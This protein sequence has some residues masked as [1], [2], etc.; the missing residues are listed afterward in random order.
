MRGRWLFSCATAF[1]LACAD[2]PEPFESAAS[3][4]DLGCPS[5][6]LEDRGR[7]RCDCALDEQ[8]TS[9]GCAPCPLADDGRVVLPFES[10]RFS[11]EVIFDGV[12]PGPGYSSG[13][14]LVI[15]QLGPGAS[16]IV[17]STE[18][19]QPGLSMGWDLRVPPG[20]YQVD[21]FNLSREPSPV[22]DE[23]RVTL[24]SFDVL[25]DREVD[26]NVE[27]T[28]VEVDLSFSDDTGEAFRDG[29][30]LF[31]DARDA[32]RTGQD[33][34]IPT[35]LDR[36][37]T[38]D[39]LRL[40]RRP[41]WVVYRSNLGHR[42][43]LGIIDLAG[44]RYVIS[45]EL[46]TVRFD[47]TL[48]VN[49]RAASS[50]GMQGQLLLGSV[51]IPGQEFGLA[52]VS[53][54]DVDEFSVETFPA[55]NHVWLARLEDGQLASL[56]GLMVFADGRVIGQDVHLQTHRL[57]GQLRLEDGEAS[58]DEARLSLWNFYSKFPVDLTP[59]GSF[60]LELPE[61]SYQLVYRPPPSDSRLPRPV[62]LQTIGDSLHVGEDMEVDFEVGVQEVQLGL[63]GLSDDVS[64]RIVELDHGGQRSSIPLEGSVE[65]EIR[66][67]PG[68][69]EAVA[70]QT[71]VLG[72]VVAFITGPRTELDLRTSSVDF[73][74]AGPDGPV[75]LPPNVELSIRR[76]D[77]SSFWRSPPSDQGPHA[78][79]PGT[80]RTRLAFA[81][82]GEP[83]EDFP[84]HGE[85]RR[86]FRVE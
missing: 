49:D 71:G 28:L 78:I 17:H 23:D 26:L 31:F 50:L 25:S 19:L 32:P 35:L 60:E 5:R 2:A 46:S 85:V 33:L 36:T 12:R 66:L 68:R 55:V 86:C 61:D 44:P 83:P 75:A 11:G 67:L 48:L 80:Y 47:G 57:R 53:A 15:R 82:F 22:P 6:C 81:G 79:F 58:W 64:V 20:R 27:T 18:G 21:L 10:V 9:A 84:V 45:R 59:S 14:N 4:E 43:D 63:E 56:G 3:C 41:H 73:G 70:R 39:S 62:G 38:Q 76:A 7:V 51:L 42:Y 77:P 8:A 37:R 74:L 1:A 29:E 52:S 69:Y 40:L 54:L 30:L 34:S 65:E 13:A 24:G 16:S 72:E